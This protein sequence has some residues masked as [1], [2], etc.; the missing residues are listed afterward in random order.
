VA[1]SFFLPA[2]RMPDQ[3]SILHLFLVHFVR[4]LLGFIE[5][6]S[7]ETA[8]VILLLLAKFNEFDELLC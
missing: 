4:L 2:I 5:E 1:A 7:F 3:I 8:Y 6:S